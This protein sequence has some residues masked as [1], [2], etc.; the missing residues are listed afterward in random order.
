MRA[1]EQYLNRR[2][3]TDARAYFESLNIR[4]DER[5]S[6]WCANHDI[7]P[8]SAPLWGVVARPEEELAPKSKATKSAK[9]KMTTK[10]VTP[11]GDA[12]ETWHVPAAERPL[13]KSAKR[14]TTKKRKGSK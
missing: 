5:L 8:P 13:R 11:P 6:E 2:N 3:I 9:P 4:S 1:F 10:R 14:S 7:E 12:E